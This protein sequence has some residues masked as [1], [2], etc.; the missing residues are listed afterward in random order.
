MIKSSK[1]FSLLLSKD[2]VIGALKVLM[3]THVQHVFIINKGNISE[4]L[5]LDPIYPKFALN[6]IIRI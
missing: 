4:I 3:S 1:I 5:G 2:G 6:H